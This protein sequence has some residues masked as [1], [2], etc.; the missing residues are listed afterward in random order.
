MER[1]NIPIVINTDQL[2]SIDAIAENL[3]VSRSQVLRAFINVGIAF[4]EDDPEQIR[5]HLPTLLFGRGRKSGA[6][7]PPTPTKQV[8]GELRTEDVLP[9][10]SQEK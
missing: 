3:G 5:K 9:L 8:Q 1:K 2:A 7:T 4:F 10:G 6:N